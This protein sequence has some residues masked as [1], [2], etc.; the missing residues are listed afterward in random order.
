LRTSPKQ[1]DVNSA[2]ATA[3]FEDRRVAHAELCR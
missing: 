3:Y 2:D 1:F